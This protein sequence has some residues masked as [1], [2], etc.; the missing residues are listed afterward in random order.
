MAA[1]PVEVRKSA[2]VPAAAMDPWR[3]LRAE[4][5]RAFDRVTGGFSSFPQLFEMG[6]A[7]R[8]MSSF[9]IAAPA[10]DI[11]DGATAFKL[12]AELPGMSEKDVHVSQSGDTLTI[13]GEKKQET[14]QTEKNYY[15]SERS[16]GAFQRSFTIPDDVDRDK[17]AADF[18][19]GVLTVTMPKTKEAQKQRTIEVK[20]A[21]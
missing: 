19:N 3:A 13:K 4:L 17:I 8:I 10:V 9:S 16:Y 1:T 12:T 18:A 6:P 21:A 15:L 2:P 5:D 11:T 7:A 14:E 20:A